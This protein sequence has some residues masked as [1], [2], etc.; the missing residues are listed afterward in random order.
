MLLRP[1][2]TARAIH[3]ASAFRFPQWGSLRDG[4]NTRSTR[5]F[6]AR[7]MPMRASIVGPFFGDQD[8]AFHGRLPLR[9]LML[10]L[11]QL[12][13]VVAGI[14]ERDKLAPAGKRDGIVELSRPTLANGANPSCRTRS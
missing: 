8:Q 2:H 3:P 1:G 14:L 4:L 7:M 10:G 9:R 12:G 11:G 13:D 5:R 6:S